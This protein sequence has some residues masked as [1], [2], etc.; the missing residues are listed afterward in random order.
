MGTTWSVKLCDPDHRMALE[1]L[2]ALIQATLERITGQ[3]SAW[4]PDSAISRLNRAERGWYQ[5]PKELYH[6]L[7]HAL[8]LAQQTEGAYDPTLGALVDLW[9]FGPSGSRTSTPDAAT[10]KKAMIHAG[11]QHASVNTEHAA[12]WQ[13]GGLVFDVCSIGKG[14]GVDQI[15]AVLD[16]RGIEH[17]L[18]EVGGELKAK[19]LNEQHKPWMV[20]IEVPQMPPAQ[21]A[22]QPAHSS[23]LPVALSNLA[24]AT[25][26]DYRRYFEQDGQRYAHTFNPATG[27]PVTHDLTSVS[28]LHSQ[29]MMADALATAL[30]SMGPQHGPSYAE[31]HH[32]PAL[33]MHRHTNDLALT[34]TAQFDRLAGIESLV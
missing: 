15:A 24:I 11:W 16:R 1:T 7:S 22:G 28:V 18:V 21:P 8:A 29:C 26:G 32:I 10:I 13:P 27:Q 12:I 31:T 5:P 9:G 2:D 25:S 17:Y 34:W 4:D 30:F 20:D 6:V 23:S 33:F 14:Y 3:M 19:G